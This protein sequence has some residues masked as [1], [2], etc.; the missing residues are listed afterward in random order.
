VK[1][2]AT[3]LR[4]GLPVDVDVID[5][6]PGDV[7]RL[8][9]GQI[10]PA[11][12]RLLDATGLECDE[13]VLTGESLPAEKHVPAAD[14]HSP[15]AEL[16][17]CVLMG[18]VVR[19]GLGT[20]VVV[21]TGARAEFGR[22]A[23]GLGERQSE[24][25]FKAGLRRFSMLLLQVAITLTTLIFV[26]NLLLHRSLLDSLLFSLAIA[27][28]ITP[29]LLPA[30]VSTSLATGSRQLAK[31]K[32]L[33]KRLVCIEDLGDM[34]VLVTDETGTLTEGRISFVTAL[35]PAGRPSER[36]SMLGL[37]ATD[38]A[39]GAGA[40][41]LDEALWQAVRSPEG[42]RR[43]GQLPFDHERRRSS[44]VVESDAGRR[45]IVKGAPE[46]VL[47]CVQTVP[48]STA[49]LLQEHFAAGS[50]VVA[51]ASRPAPGL[52]EPTPRDET[53]LTLEGILVFL[54]RPK[55]SAAKSLRR[56]DALGITVKI[57]TGDNPLVAQKVRADLSLAPGE[58]LTGPQI[59]DLDDDALAVAAE[60]ASVFAR[61]SP[62]QKARLIK[63]LRVT[64]V[65]SA[66]S[67]TA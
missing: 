27:V 36:V 18:T 37:L 55:T 12:I 63:L 43:V 23:I 9:L 16:T 51:V 22:I 62:E 30:V 53:S 42:Y 3:V 48:D 25:D 64:D 41:P 44:V 17:S 15:L 61:V 10:V 13:S 58:T 8:S 29:Q 35:D 2:R 32:V 33:V 66:S 39:D 11:D 1:H 38:E 45:L 56:L 34:D 5:L 4:D 26:V 60:Q 6:V 46:S 49:A 67:A 40:N 50:R 57:A 52:A 59:D 47:S 24:T 19:A 20:G 31:R 65:R 28:G 7:V 14:A 21:A 54:D